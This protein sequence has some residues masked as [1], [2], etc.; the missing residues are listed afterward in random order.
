MAHIGYYHKNGDTLDVFTVPT[1]KKGMWWYKMDVGWIDHPRFV[2]VRNK[3]GWSYLLE[4]NSEGLEIFDEYK[5][6][7]ENYWGGHQND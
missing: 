2:M 4:S 5:G 7:I 3:Y 1:V 6:I